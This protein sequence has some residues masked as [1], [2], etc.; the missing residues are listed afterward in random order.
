MS[1]W[2][3][4]QSESDID[5]VMET[6]GD[7]HDSCIVSV[8]YKSGVF[9]DEKNDMCFG[10]ANEREL[11][12]LFH[13]QWEPKVFELCFT[14]VRQMHLVGWQKNYLASISEA[15]L[16]FCDNILPGTPSRLIVWSDYD[17]FTVS[18]SKG[19]IKEPA[20]TYIIANSLKWRTIE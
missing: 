16:F 15:A 13:C 2:K 20:D 1:E 18:G 12:V 11:T 5:E 6:L 4:I 14:G 19:P 8:N 9:V 17:Y 7:F 3:E 10:S